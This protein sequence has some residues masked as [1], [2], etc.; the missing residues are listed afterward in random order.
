MVDYKGSKNNVDIICPIHG[1]FHQRP[2]HHLSG[3]GCP[4]CANSSSSY[5]S[6]IILMIKNA[7]IE[8]INMQNK[9]E[10]IKKCNLIHFNKYD[11]TCIELKHMKDKIHIICPI[12]GEFIQRAD[13]HLGGQGCPLCKLYKTSKTKSNTV[14]EFIQK[15]NTIHKNKYNYSKVNYINAK[16]KVCIV[17]PRH[18]DFLQLPSNHIHKTHPRGCPKCN[19]GIK[20]S[21]EEFINKANIVHNNKYDYSNVKYFDCVTKICILCNKHGE[22]WQ[23]PRAHLRGQG[24]PTCGIEASKLKNTSTTVNFIL[25]SN[26]LHENKYDYSKSVYVNNETKTCIICPKHGE[27]WQ[28]PSNHLRG[29]GCPKCANCLSHSENEICKCLN[30]LEIEQRNRKILGGKEIDIYIPKSKIGIEFNGLYWHSEENGKD[31][32]YHLNKLNECNKNGI[33]LL[34]IFEDEWINH[35]DICEYL[36]K[37]HIGLNTNSIVIANECNV[38]ENVNKEE[39]DKFLEANDINGSVDSDIVIAV[40]YKTNIVGAMTLNKNNK[41][42][43]TINRI[44]TNIK[45]NCIGIGQMLFDYFK[46]HFDFNTITFFADRRWVINIENNIYTSLGFKVDSFISPLFTFYNPYFSKRM[47]LKREKITDIENYTRIW[48]C[49]FVK[50]VYTNTVS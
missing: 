37:S 46:T 15:A 9:E 50:Y 11:Y 18:G 14:E 3:C 48:D 40:S 28:T 49:G 19:G 12:H 1:V 16:T 43:Y 39:I 17:C 29:E 2:N 44:T 33:E 23:E 10:Y 32:N 31:K 41:Q 35:R 45:Y 13:A 30:S 26:K 20:F 6:E 34:Q 24:C 4:K 47:R 38:C 8:K 27:F 42:E 5:E 21:Q 7:Y 36:I 25:K 22:F